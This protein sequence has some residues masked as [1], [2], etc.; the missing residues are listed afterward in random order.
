MPG[1]LYPH[2]A[3]FIPN[4]RYELSR[5]MLREL[6]LRTPIPPCSTDPRFPIQTSLLN[7]AL[8]LM[9]SLAIT[10][11]SLPN[12]AQHTLGAES[13]EFYVAPTSHFIDTVKDLTD[14]LDYASEDIN[15]MDDDA[16][17]E[18]SQNPLFTGCWMTTFHI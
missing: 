18:K 9:R 16:G 7:E 15:G 8:D 17:E 13:G 2:Q 5:S 12:Y 3:G 1:S 6:D 14:M 10:K 4:T 11:E